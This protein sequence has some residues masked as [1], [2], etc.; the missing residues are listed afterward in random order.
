[1]GLTF[2]PNTDDLRDAPA[3]DLIEQLDRLGARVKA[4]DPIVTSPTTH[5][6]LIKVLMA[7]NPQQLAYGCDALVLVTD[8][9][10]FQQLN[11]AQLAR[12]MTT[13]VIVDGR[14]FLD[15]EVLAAAGFYYVGIGRLTT[16]NTLV[17][18]R[19]QGNIPG[20]S[21]RSARVVQVA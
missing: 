7:A 16:V 18:K 6:Q 15:P 2:K 21:V 13:P 10:Q 19:L 1:M 20:I 11:Y 5:P 8:W 14:N 4:Y 12:L 3:L 17:E 9:Q